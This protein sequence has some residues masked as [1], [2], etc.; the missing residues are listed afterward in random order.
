MNVKKVGGGM[1]WMIWRKEVQVDMKV[2]GSI[3][4]TY[5]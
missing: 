4:P 3:P 1:G 5:N 2:S